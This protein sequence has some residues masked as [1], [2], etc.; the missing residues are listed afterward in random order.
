MSR[1]IVP[2]AVIIF[3]LSKFVRVL[4]HCWFDWISVLLRFIHIEYC[5]VAYTIPFDNIISSNNDRKVRSQFPELT[6]S[7]VTVLGEKK[8]RE[9]E[10]G[11]PVCGV[12]ERRTNKT[13]PFLMIWTHCS[14]YLC[15]Q[16]M[17]SVLILM[18][19]YCSLLFLFQQYELLFCVEN[20]FD[21]V[22][23]LVESLMRKY[24]L[25]DSTLFIGE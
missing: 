11:I 9:R 3:K 15:Q 20:R 4:T 13:K 10:R 6:H 8:G 22:V 24:P 23:G 5:I 17:I 14:D 21:P 2:C 12:T 16:I 7:T 18:R 19:I 1:A 25:V